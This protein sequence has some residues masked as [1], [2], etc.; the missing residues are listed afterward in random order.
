V[1]RLERSGVQDI[2]PAFVYESGP[3]LLI[4]G[5]GDYETVLVAAGNR[6]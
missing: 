6:G 1:G 5:T 3:D 4:F 2:I